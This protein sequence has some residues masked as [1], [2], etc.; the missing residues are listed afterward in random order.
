MKAEITS[1]CVLLELSILLRELARPD[2]EI[3]GWSIRNFMQAQRLAAGA[4]TAAGVAGGCGLIEG[5]GEL[6]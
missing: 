1:G 5:W 2:H 4:M 3:V 6:G